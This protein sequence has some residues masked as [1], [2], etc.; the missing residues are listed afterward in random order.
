MLGEQDILISSR[1][2]PTSRNPFP[3]TEDA[4]DLYGAWTPTSTL[5][6][7]LRG[8]NL[9]CSNQLR[10]AGAGLSQ[11]HKLCI[12]RG[13]TPRL[14]NQFNR[15]V[16]ES[17]NTGGRATRCGSLR[18]V[19]FDD[20]TVACRFDPCLSDQ[21]SS[22]PAVPA[23]AGCM[24]RT[25]TAWGTGLREKKYAANS[26]T[27]FHAVPVLSEQQSPRT[28]ISI[29]GDCSAR[30]S[31]QCKPSVRRVLVASQGKS[32]NLAAA[33]NTFSSMMFHGSRN[34]EPVLS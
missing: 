4:K 28:L 33:W 34:C 16:V 1:P 9:T 32:R 19:E 22:D 20:S 31:T 29:M 10:A 27:T 21:S 2:R 8:G 5:T 12:E 6:V 14:R 17:E 30:E 11:P 18:N 25:K 26:S 13:S 7:S 15:R 24:G 23:K 3:N